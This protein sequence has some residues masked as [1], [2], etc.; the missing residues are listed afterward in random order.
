MHL[1]RAF[2]DREGWELGCVEEGQVWEAGGEVGGRRPGQLQE[3][4]DVR[5]RGGR[6]AGARAE[7]SPGHLGLL[8]S[9]G[10]LPASWTRGWIPCDARQPLPCSVSTLVFPQSS[11]LVCSTC[12]ARV[13]G[14]TEPGWVGEVRGAYWTGWRVP[15]GPSAGGE[16]REPQLRGPRSWPQ[17]PRVQDAAPRGPWAVAGAHVPSRAEESGADHGDSSSQNRGAQEDPGFPALSAFSPNQGPSLWDG[18]A[19]LQGGSS[20]PYSL[21]HMPIICGHAL[22][23]S[24]GSALYPFS[25][26]VS[27]QAS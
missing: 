4:P 25:R 18:A 16:P 10:P 22:T 19:H 13:L 21:T 14:R 9:G 8:L 27:V 6:T 23:G 3:C 26:C 17:S 7:P 11:A 12:S 15:Q 1:E 5:A 2:K 20:P 24:P